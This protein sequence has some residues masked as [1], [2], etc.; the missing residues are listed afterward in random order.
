MSDDDP[1]SCSFC[2]RDAATVCTRCGRPYCPAHGRELCAGCL[3]PAGALPSPSLYRGSLAAIG[4]A[5]V[6]GVLVLLHPLSLP[7]EHRLA[8]AVSQNPAAVQGGSVQAG[9]SGGPGVP[10][11]LPADAFS[12]TPAVLRSYTVVLNDTL[13]AIALSFDTTVAAIQ[14]AHPGV[15]QGNL[16]AGQELLIP[17][18]D[19]TPRPA[20]TAAAPPAT[21]TSGP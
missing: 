1:Q 12:P 19:G 6:A 10:T 16:K 2:T 3:D 13:S 11:P 8:Q 5:A 14:A 7:G 17:P 4:I 18:P 9:R 20:G 21:A 15:N